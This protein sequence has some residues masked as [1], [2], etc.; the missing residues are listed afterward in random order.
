MRGEK[1]EINKFKIF[2]AIAKK[3]TTCNE[4]P[5]LLILIGVNALG[6]IL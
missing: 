1:D 6:P 5:P 3:T 2:V 4:E